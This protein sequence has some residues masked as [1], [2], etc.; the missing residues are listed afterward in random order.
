MPTNSLSQTNSAPFYNAVI[1]DQTISSPAVVDI[2]NGQLTLPNGQTYRVTKLKIKGEE[3]DL[4]KNPLT[5]EQ[6]KAVQ[7]FANALFK[8]L[9]DTQF[10][11]LN[12]K[13]ANLK[14]LTLK[15]E[16]NHST[17]ITT[18][19]EDQSTK[20]ENI[21]DLSSMPGI[22]Q[23]FHKAFF[24]NIPKP[25]LPSPPSSQ[26][27]NISPKP[28]PTKIDPSEMSEI[29]E[30]LLTES[31]ELNE[32]SDI[33]K[34]DTPLTQHQATEIPHKILENRKDIILHP[35]EVNG[36]AIATQKVTR[37]DT[38][39]KLISFLE[40]MLKVAKEKQDAGKG[41]D[42]EIT[43]YEKALENAK[44]QSPKG[45]WLGSNYFRDHIKDSPSFD[46]AIK[47]YVSAP[48]N[49]RYQELQEVDGT[50]KTGFCRVGIMSD[51][52]NG[53]F[54][55]K[56]LENMQ[57][58][59]QLKDQYIKDIEQK[60]TKLTGNQLQSAKY[61]IQQLKQ[62]FIAQLITERTR[63]IEQQMIQLVSEQV[64]RNPEKV[65]EALTTSGTF[66]LVHVSLLN[67]KKNKLDKTGW[68]HDERVEMEDMAE[69]FK[70]FKGKQIVFVDNEQT[71]LINENTLY[72]SLPYEMTEE[73]KKN[74]SPAVLTLNTY[75]FNTSVQGNIDNT[76]TQLSI[77]QAGRDHLIA[78]Y[79]GFKE[80]LEQLSIVKQTGYQV[81]EDLL[82]DLLS[83]PKLAVSLGCLSAKDRTGFVAERLMI[84]NLPEHQEKFA[85]KIFDPEGA[86]VRIVAENTPHFQ[87]LKV[88]PM[89]ELPGYSSIDKVSIL[90]NLAFATLK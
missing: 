17:S 24:K 1:S 23:E 42:E 57:K 63:V 78:D 43:Y 41:S 6:L 52:R 80:S 45:N 61:A 82:M 15:T 67:Q 53:W 34:E 50:K 56:D 38:V 20:Q 73:D 5:N 86:A 44:A 70:K 90:A 79:P 68:V 10:S 74:S 76:E 16:S 30:D 13:H 37:I 35:Y 81:A 49:M 21:T 48:I 58:D 85:K 31:D 14:S 46:E 69:I 2:K 22:I 25:N 88:N 18:T 84:R 75:F 51:M 65:K 12:L 77:N 54:S 28:D 19:R 64:S 36:K 40:N 33:E 62:S 27:P 60:A 26:S 4:G 47:S 89:A 9:E 11:N 55:L 83:N 32:D 3:I 29:E 59:P 7:Q 39:N 66:D 72:L 71:P 8:K 87:V